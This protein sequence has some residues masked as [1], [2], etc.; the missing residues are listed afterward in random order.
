MSMVSKVLTYNEGRGR[1]MAYG[2]KFPQG[3]VRALSAEDI[4]KIAKS[5]AYIPV[6]VHEPGSDG[7]RRLIKG[8]NDRQ[9]MIRGSAAAPPVRR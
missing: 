7:S 4:D 5:G 3:L 9:P 8:A 2:K 1:K 6:G